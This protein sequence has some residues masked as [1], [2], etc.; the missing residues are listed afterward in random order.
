[1]ST[2]TLIAERDP[3]FMIHRE[4]YIKCTSGMY[5]D[6]YILV[7]FF[8]NPLLP[9]G[10]WTSSEEERAATGGPQGAQQQRRAPEVTPC[11]AH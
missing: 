7:C 6:Y 11:P 2:D 9:T 5:S 8:S 3:G 4:P 1:M 10:R